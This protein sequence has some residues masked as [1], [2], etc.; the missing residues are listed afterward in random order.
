[1]QLKCNSTKIFRTSAV[2]EQGIDSIFEYILKMIKTFTH[3]N[4]KQNDSIQ[5]NRAAAQKITFI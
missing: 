5:T 4:G 3:S 1:M 2:I